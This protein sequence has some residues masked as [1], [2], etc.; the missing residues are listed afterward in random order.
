[1]RIRNVL[2]FIA[3]AAAF[4]MA[5]ASAF[6]SPQAVIR[7]CAKDGTLNHHYSLSDLKNALKKLPTDV[8]E[9]TNCRDVINQAETQGG[10]G[11]SGGSGLGGPGG[12]AGGGTG[13]GSGPSAAD[14]R[15]LDSAIHSN[16]SAPTL[17]L[18]GRKVVPGSGG[19]FKT[20]SATGSLP[21]PVLLA[22]IAVAALTAAGG[23]VA[24]RRRFPEAVGAALRVPQAAGARLRVRQVLGATLRIFRR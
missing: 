23:F 10:G 18:G 5:S 13:G 4:G 22:L 24:V 11:G 14:T 8:D 3:V 21:V 16:G 20:A 2:I 12:T 6:A 1:M 9:Y 19:L 15:A 17:S 7:D